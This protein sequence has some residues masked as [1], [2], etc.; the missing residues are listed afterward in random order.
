MGGA[1]AGATAFD[2]LTARRLI[3]RRR[4][5]SAVNCELPATASAALRLRRLVDANAA[6]FPSLPEF[7]ATMIL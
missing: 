3:A 4:D 2:A 1:E 6:F 7:R 5:E